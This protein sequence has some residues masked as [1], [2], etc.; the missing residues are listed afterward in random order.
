MD[1]NPYDQIVLDDD[2]I[3]YYLG[4]EK[5]RY[6]FQP[7]PMVIDGVLTRFPK[8]RMTQEEFDN[9]FE[10]VEE[11]TQD[12]WFYEHE[13]IYSIQYNEVLKMIEQT[14]VYYYEEDNVYT[15]ICLP[16]QGD[17]GC[18]T[19]LFDYQRIKTYNQVE[20]LVDCGDWVEFN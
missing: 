13:L 17:R 10:C 3:V 19:H 6:T 20:K 14:N 18:A 12:G 4:F 16:I 2:S 1:F 15:F 7:K 8:V 5:G 9:R 11:K